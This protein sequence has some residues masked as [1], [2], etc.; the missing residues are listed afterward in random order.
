MI[1]H[2]RKQYPLLK[3]RRLIAL[4]ALAATMTPATAMLDND[5][6]MIWRSGANLYFKYAEQDSPDYGDN[7]HPVSL[8]PAEITAVLDAVRVWDKKIFRDEEAELLFSPRQSHLL[9]EQLAR[10]LEKAGPR[11][12]IVF[13]LSKTNRGLLGLSDRAFVCGRAFY[14][15]DRPNII[16]G[17]HDRARNEAFES[18]Y[19]PSGQGRVPYSFYHGSRSRP[20]SF[21]Q[22]LVRMSG[23]EN[24][25]TDEL[26]RD[27][28]VIDL[29]AAGQ[30]LLAEKQQQSKPNADTRAIRREAATLSR[31]MRLEM[32]RMRKQMQTLSKGSTLS[33][34]ERLA[35]L[36]QL[37][38]G[39]LIT[40]EEYQAKRAE[41]LNEL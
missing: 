25:Q 16:L 33:I 32:A 13:T 8:K 18:A 10:G 24:R 12:D 37:R 6:D 22:K 28:L 11:Q 40:E 29:D 14:Q 17:E 1:N 35:R 30:A 41:I 23:V 9:G 21:K 20:S 19:D 5:P 4:L 3:R 2:Y 36:E 15:Q 39:E 31:E 27:W 38:T 34:E 7:D 26:R